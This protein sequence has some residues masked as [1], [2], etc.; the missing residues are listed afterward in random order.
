MH[1][2]KKAEKKGDDGQEDSLESPSIVNPTLARTISLNRKIA[3][4]QDHDNDHHFI[5]TICFKILKDPMDCEKCQTS[6]CA[7]CL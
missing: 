2:A 6:F 4:A 7:D 3:N 1:E 5:C